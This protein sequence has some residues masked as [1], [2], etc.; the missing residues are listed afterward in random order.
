MVRNFLCLLFSLFFL[1]NV[2]AEGLM[3]KEAVEYY[4][5]ALK[6]QQ[7]TNFTAAEV[8]YQKILY[9]DPYNSNWQ[10]FILN[11]RGAILA[12]QGDISN[13]EILFQKALEIDPNY[14]PPKLNLG[15][16]YEKQRTELESIKYWLKVLNID[17]DK[18]KPQGFVLGEEQ[19]AKN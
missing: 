18:V 16:I 4:N 3:S 11:N 9:M 19:K 10:M 8:L 7:A 2:F 14:L 15:F 17:L 1:G 6:L 12:Q 5:E 13:A